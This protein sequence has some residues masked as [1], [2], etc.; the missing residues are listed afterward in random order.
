MEFKCLKELAA[1]SNA[2]FKE[3]EP[4][5]PFT[6][7][8]IGGN[9]MF[10]IKP[11]SWETIPRIIKFINNE[12][13]P[14]KVMGRG[15][16]LLI[17][18]GDLDFGVIHI[19]RMDGKI[20]M[21]DFSAKVDS[22]VLLSEFCKEAFENSLVGL[23]P[24]SMIPGSVGGAIV[25]NAG[26]YGKSVFSFV[27]EVTLLDREGGEIRLIPSEIEIGYRKTNIRD[28]G[29]VKNA[30]FQMKKGNRME[31]DLRVKEFARKRDE[32][33]PWRSRTAGSVFKNPEGDF[34]GRILEEAGFKG[35]RNGGAAFSDLHCNF[36]INTGKAT[37]REA[38]SLVEAAREKALSKGFCLEYEME[39]WGGD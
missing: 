14:F 1:A 36:L 28:L 29:I 25:M 18:D 39:V 27:R 19:L 10:Y 5:A 21:D 8:K 23:E 2:L 16:N 3:K 30:L 6:S 37:F 26:A 24:L 13:L 31:I 7:L 22:D 4:L 34:A 38:F 35:K 32:S 9:A 17:K 33:Q 20:R 15:T 12:K 11:E